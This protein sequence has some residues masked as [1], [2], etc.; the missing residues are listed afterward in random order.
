VSHNR[1]MR[2]LLP[3]LLL[4]L[5]L[6]AHAKLGDPS[7]GHRKP[8]PV[9]IPGRPHMHTVK[10]SQ[11]KAGPMINVH[12]AKCLATTIY[13][14]ARGESVKGQIA[15][16][17]TA[18]N[19]AVKGHICDAVLAP[20]QYSIYNDN[21]PLRAAA[22]SLTVQPE[23]KNVIDK[24]SWKQAQS[25]A[26]AILAGQIKDP[27]GGATHYFNEGLVHQLGYVIPKWK[28]EFIWVRQI[29]DHQFYKPRQKTKLIM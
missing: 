25:L 24:I 15:V 18:V 2:H 29:G 22:M 5:A 19:R 26:Y 11:H 28:Q 4:P 13:G 20:K 6:S 3:I 9:A 1:H 16:A 14:E 23:T 21:E 17:W 27:T 8:E 12:E 7:L 10:V